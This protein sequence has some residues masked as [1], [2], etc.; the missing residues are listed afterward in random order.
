[1]SRIEAEQSLAS[2]KTALAAVSEQGHEPSEQPQQAPSQSTF[3]P[4]DISDS[5]AGEFEF[6]TFDSGRKHLARVVAVNRKNVRVRCFN[7]KTGEWR[8]KD[9]SRERE[10]CIPLTAAEAEETFPGSVAA[11]DNSNPT[12]LNSPSAGYEVTT[13]RTDGAPTGSALIADLESYIRSYVMLCPRTDGTRG[14]L[15]SE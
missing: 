8:T 2:A 10:A 11:W 4:P 6:V 14:G 13:F 15:E 5:R 9:E 3:A 1:M 12:I 7:K